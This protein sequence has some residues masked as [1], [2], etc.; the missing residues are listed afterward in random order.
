GRG[1]Y[2]KFRA[3]D[4]QI[5]EGDRALSL[6]FRVPTAWRGELLDVLIRGDSQPSGFTSDVASLAGMTVK[7]QRVGVGRFLVAT[8][9]DDDPQGRQ[10]A[11]RLAD[12]EAEM[13]H[14]IGSLSSGTLVSL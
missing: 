11:R 9:R 4:Q 14:Q 12:A 3:T 13:R 2:F 6:T 5:I 7:P 1:V 10:L 8:Y